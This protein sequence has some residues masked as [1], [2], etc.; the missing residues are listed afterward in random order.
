MAL[1]I[2]SRLLTQ[3]GRFVV[4]IGTPPQRVEV[5]LDTG[6]FEL[7]VDP[8]CSTASTQDQAERCEKAGA[9]DPYSSSTAADV[10]VVNELPYGKGVVDVAYVTDDIKLPGCRM[11]RMI[12]ECRSKAFLTLR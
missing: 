4:D 12:P 10:G 2:G 5:V 9:Y 6:S 3:K 11:S 1:S 8:K 7:W